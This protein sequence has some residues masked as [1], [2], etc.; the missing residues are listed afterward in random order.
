[1]K[2]FAF[3]AVLFAVVAISSLAFAQQGDVALGFGTV[4]SSGSCNSSGYCPE[5]GGLYPAI[6]ADVIFHRRIGFEYDVAWR[7]SQASYPIFNIPYRP[8]INAFNADFQ[9]KLGKKIGLDILGGIGV[10]ST[11]FYSSNYNC[12]FTGC[13]NYVSSDHFLLDAGAGLRYYVWHHV[14][15]RP[16]FRYYWI[17]NN[18]ND[19][20]SNNI[21]RV[22]GS[23]GYTIGPE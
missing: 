8:I 9:P 7:G 18:T 23:I 14:F 2:K 20:S 5:K 16:E 21:L 22:G 3:L 12:N 4:M 17:N 13:I 19:F 10:Q 6:S 1:M 11:R 15:V